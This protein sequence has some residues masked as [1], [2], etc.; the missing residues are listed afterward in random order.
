[1][2]H[3]ANLSFGHRSLSDSLQ[4]HDDSDAL[5]S[6]EIYGRNKVGA[7]EPV[8]FSLSASWHI[9]WSHWGRLV[10]LTLVSVQAKSYDAAGCRGL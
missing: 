7:R 2:G 10:T 5:F 9:P 8:I 3:C 4:M 6:S 1:V